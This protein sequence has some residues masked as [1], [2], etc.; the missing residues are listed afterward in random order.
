MAS[1]GSGSGVAFRFAIGLLAISACAAWLSLRIGA[2]TATARM[3]PVAA[4][5]E[6][7]RSIPVH[8]EGGVPRLRMRALPPEVVRIPAG[9]LPFAQGFLR[10]GDDHRLLIVPFPEFLGLWRGR[11]RFV[12]V[13]YL[14]TN[15]SVDL[16]LRKRDVFQ[17]ASLP[18][19]VLRRLR[20]AP[21]RV[22]GWEFG[23]E[24]TVLYDDTGR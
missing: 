9:A 2:L 17:Y 22:V 20:N 8:F 11:F 12:K 1:K 4:A 23:E 14:G 24:P 6:G 18:E 7:R 19:E 21:V 15:V 3:D 5:P 13:H 16:D 10:Q